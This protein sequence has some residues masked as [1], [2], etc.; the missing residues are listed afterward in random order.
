MILLTILWCLCVLAKF[1]SEN[2]TIVFSRGEA[3]YYCIRI[4]SLLTTFRGTLLAFGEARMFNCH[5]DT[6]IDIVFKR[7]LDNGMT[8]SN[9]QIMYR[10]NASGENFNW[11]GNFAPIQLKT[12]QRI[13][14]PFCKNN[15]ILM[16]V[17][18]D[19]D[20][21]TF[22]QPQIIFNVTKPNWKWV[23][24]G[25]PSGLALQ[26]NRILIPGDYSTVE[27]IRAGSF[28]VGF[29]MLND[30]DGQVDK[31]YLGGEYRLDDYF[32]NEGQAV[33]LLPRA[34]SIFINA[35]SYSTKRIGAY[36]DD[37]GITFKRVVLL[38]TLI[39][40]LHGCEGSTIYDSKSNQLFYSGLA[41]TSIIRT[42]L[43]LHISTDN[44]ES[45][46]YIKSICLGP[47]G[48]SS[49]T[50]MH[51]QSIGVLYEKGSIIGVPDSLTFSIVY[52]QTEKNIDVSSSMN[53]DFNFKTFK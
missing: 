19:D 21:L 30:F 43:S 46:S 32:P 5:D 47:S 38:N 17:Y 48:Y 29:V 24:L 26:S 37:G 2:E 7:S 3:G 1:S 36:S 16:Q 22:S 33:E 39:Q 28:S 18:S 49:L 35:R 44:G 50:L 40:P 14:V 52:N 34:N 9:L 51:N 15:L 20:G 23:A 42:N 10:G 4:P 53:S 41:E 13:L 8:W 31:W 11:V 6:Q 45:W 27:N 25:P 12:N